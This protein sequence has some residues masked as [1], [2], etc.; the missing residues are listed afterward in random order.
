VPAR[1]LYELACDWRGVPAG[2]SVA[3]CLRAATPA[4]PPGSDLSPLAPQERDN[5]R[6]PAIDVNRRGIFYREAD[7]PA[8]LPRF[9]V[10]ANGDELAGMIAAFMATGKEAV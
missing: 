2:T 1:Q 5:A 10:G 4:H 9:S 8:E 3:G 7:D 6:I